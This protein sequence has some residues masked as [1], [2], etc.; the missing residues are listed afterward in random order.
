MHNRLDARSL[1]LSVLAAVENNCPC[2]EA[3]ASIPPNDLPPNER[4]LLVELVYGILRTEIRLQALLEHY[5]HQNKA[6]P[7]TLRHIFFLALYS[8]LFLERIPP[9]AVL[10]SAVQMAKERFGQGLGNFVNAVLRR[11]L[12][13]RDTLASIECVRRANDPNE[14]QLI[15]TLATFYSLPSWLLRFWIEHY[16]FGNALLLAKQSITKPRIGILLTNNAQGNAM[17]KS[18]EKQCGVEQIS[19]L[20]FSLT[21]EAYQNFCYEHNAAHLHTQGAFSYLSSGSQWVLNALGLS[22]WKEPVWDMCAGFGGKS[23]ALANWRVPVSLCTDISQKRL[24]GLTKDFA[25]RHLPLPLCCVASGTMPPLSH[26]DGNIL[27]DA[28]CSGLGIL[29][30]RPDI[31]R[32][33]T[34]KRSIRLFPKQQEAL[35]T[36]GLRY[37]TPKHELCYI[38]CTHNPLENGLLVRAVLE[39]SG[40]DLVAEWET[41][42]ENP[43]IEGMYGALIRRS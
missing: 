37:L 33:R 20:G 16:G 35:L 14:D 13:D 41:P 30:R 17:A 24:L 32:N 19:S 27:I 39:N 10:H 42:F 8:I 23:G 4:H 38:T 6:L 3:L 15:N 31:R 22:T 7:N 43:H 12:E 40:C 34:K 29:Q 18:L 21:T 9:H 36:M 25:R 11:I 2:Q 26:F 5:Q 28:P 1:C